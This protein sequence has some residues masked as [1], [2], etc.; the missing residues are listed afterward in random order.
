M[1]MLEAK[2]FP[3]SYSRANIASEMSSRVEAS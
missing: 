1:H 2:E 3:D